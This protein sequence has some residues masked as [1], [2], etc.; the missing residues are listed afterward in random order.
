L[1]SSIQLTQH[2]CTAVIDTDFALTQRQ[3][4]RDTLK[5]A[6]LCHQQ[7]QPIKNN[8]AGSGGICR[9]VPARFLPHKR[10]GDMREEINASIMAERCR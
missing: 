5:A 4:A 1:A 10:N 9:D 8:D 2:A 6:E 3:Q 7:P